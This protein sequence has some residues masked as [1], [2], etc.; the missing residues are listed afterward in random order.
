MHIPI[1]PAAVITLIIGAPSHC[2]RLRFTVTDS[3]DSDLVDP[4]RTVT[5][6]STIIIMRERESD[7]ESDSESES[8]RE[9]TRLD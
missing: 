7:S 8:E 6:S 3:T 9:S 1:V 4:D 2:D 5:Y